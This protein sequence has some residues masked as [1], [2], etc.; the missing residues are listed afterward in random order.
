[1]GIAEILAGLIGRKSERTGMW[2]FLTERSKGKNAVALQKEHND[3]MRETLE[4]AKGFDG[5]IVIRQG[6]GEWATEIYKPGPYWPSLPRPPFDRLVPRP[7][8]TPQLLRRSSSP[9]TNQAS[10]V[11]QVKRRVKRV[12][13]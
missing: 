3:G 6:N 12:D 9:A 1:M 13:Q 7:E 4:Q 11:N 10:L 8:F 2:K 5:P